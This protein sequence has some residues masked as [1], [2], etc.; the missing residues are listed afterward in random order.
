MLGKIAKKQDADPDVIIGHYVKVKKAL[1]HSFLLS[2]VYWWD[3]ASLNSKV[4][5]RLILAESYCLVR[6]F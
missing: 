4:A 1:K 2:W 5:W 3:P 6:N